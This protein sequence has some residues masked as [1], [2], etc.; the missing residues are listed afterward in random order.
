MLNI[1]ILDESY[2]KGEFLDK[3]KKRLPGNIDQTLLDYILVLLTNK[4]SQSAMTR[5]LQTFVGGQKDAKALVEWIWETL[6]VK[7][8]ECETQAQQNS[9]SEKN[10]RRLVQ[11]SKSR[12]YLSDEN[13]I[14]STRDR[15]SSKRN[16]RQIQDQDLSCESKRSRLRQ[17]NLINDTSDDEWSRAMSIPGQRKSQKR[18]RAKEIEYPRKKPS[19]G[20]LGTAASSI[21]VEHDTSQKASKRKGSNSELAIEDHLDA[22]FGP[23]EPLKLQ[24]SSVTDMNSRNST[25]IDRSSKQTKRNLNLED[26]SAILLAA[27]NEVS[28]IIPDNV[29]IKAELGSEAAAQRK[30]IEFMVDMKGISKI[31]KDLS[32]RQRDTDRPSL[33]GK[34]QRTALTV[35]SEG[36]TPESKSGYWNKK[37][38]SHTRSHDNRFRK[39]FPKYLEID[40]DDNE[41]VVIITNKK[42]VFKGS[43]WNICWDF[44]SPLGCLRPDC[45]WK[46][47]QPL[48]KGVKYKVLKKN[49]TEYK[50]ALRE[51]KLRREGVVRKMPTWRPKPVFYGG[52]N[53][54][55]APNVGNDK[56]IST[57]SETPE[58][59]CWFALQC[60]KRPHCPFWHPGDPKTKPKENA[61]E[62][63]TVINGTEGE[64]PL[65]KLEQDEVV[66][67]DDPLKPVSEPVPALEKKTEPQVVK[68]EPGEEV[69][70]EVP[71]DFPPVGL[72]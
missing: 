37:F 59:P 38:R 45:K 10:L 62:D 42:E 55:T 2:L 31:E 27:L 66:E 41:D 44:F 60:F 26:N 25:N 16:L 23:A 14:L 36:T 9:A 32:P 29:K 11:R 46:H 65:V 6:R 52:S 64:I 3:I 68:G 58:K 70:E 63:S 22:L 50:V 40:D 67:T 8:H 49:T 57:P 61:K 20:F 18:K 47:A 7:L 1:D 35:K 24:L 34:W 53:V 13:Q 4:R 33:G 30:D 71:A 5:E 56:P 48:N 54:W 21:S 72:A 39:Q 17:E 15:R 12:R 43:D 69:E 19:L 28:E 51:D